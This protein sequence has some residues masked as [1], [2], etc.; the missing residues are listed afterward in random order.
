MRIAPSILAADF[1][2]LGEQIQAVEAAGADMI[3]VDVMDG[4]FVPNLTMGPLVVEAARRVTQ[5]PLDVHLMMV[6]PDH[7]LPA[8]AEAGSSRI[9]VHLEACPNLHRTLAAIR[10]LG[11]GAGLAIN[12]H[13][14]ASLV[15]EVLHLL[16]VVLVMT[17]N[18]GFGGQRFLPETLAKIGQLRA[19]IT[20]SGREIDIAVDGGINVETA[21]DVLH[22]GAN[23]LVVGSAVY[24]AKF[25]VQEGMDRLRQVIANQPSA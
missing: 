21:A 15:S 2:R 13:T 19:M 18:P 9:S 24:S 14:P 3:H 20:A 11:C 7:L 4:R 1:T 17:V 8:F 6:E 22:A 10:D 12:P 16:D 25:S 5:M 23:V